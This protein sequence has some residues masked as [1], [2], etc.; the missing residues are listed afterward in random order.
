[1]DNSI[2]DNNFYIISEDYRLINFNESVAKTYEGIKIGDYCYKATMKRNEP[3]KHCP[4]AGNSDCDCPIYYD[5]FYDTWMEAVFAKME[6]GKYAVTCRPAV[7]R[8]IRVFD[9]MGKEEKEELIKKLAGAAANKQLMEIEARLVHAEQEQQIQ[10]EEI[11]TLNEQLIEKQSRTEELA[12]EQEAQIEEIT[13]L[14]IELDEQ[15]IILQNQQERAMLRIKT[16]ADAIRG[17]FRIAKREEGY[18]TKYVSTQLADM[19]G[20]DVDEFMEL[21]KD[22][23]GALIHEEDVERALLNARETVDDNDNHIAAY[24]IRCKDGSWKNVE[25]KSKVIQNYNDEDEIWSFIVDKDE[26]VRISNTLKDVKETKKALEIAREQA[27]SANRAKSAFLFNMSHDIRTPMNA[28]MGFTDLLEKEITDNDTAK[29]Y[30]K[31]I[32]AANSFLLSLINNV[33]EMARI[34]SGKMAVENTYWNVQAFNDTIYSIFTESMNKKNIKF[35]RTVE[36]EHQAILC[37]ATKVREIFLNLLSNALKYTNP[38]GTIIFALKEIPSDREGYALF[39][40]IVEDNGIGMSEQFKEHIFDAFSRERTS[41]E[42]RVEGSGIGMSIVKNLIDIMDG[43][44]DVESEIGKGTKITVTLPHKIATEKDRNIVGQIEDRYA[45]VKFSGKRILLAEDNDLNAEIAQTIL[46]QVDFEVER[47]ENGKRCVEMLQ[48][49][50]AYYY[51]LILMDIQMPEMNGY[52]ATKAIRCLVDKAKAGIPIIAMT[53]NAFEEDKRD[54]LEAGMD[55]HLAK[56]IRINELMKT[57][58]NCLI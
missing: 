58:V 36:V 53:A 47:A 45:D 4:V 39:Q 49:A 55:G 20:Y 29:H 14:N 8:G 3:C 16:M 38:G 51:D 19:L 26:L 10:L 1:M 37:D 13:A 46:S 24:R 40:T 52:E 27:E 31:R 17:G 7:N 43:T 5:P 50:D 34:E 57:M 9:E 42:S 56:P 48:A 18:P 22:T 15:K 28:I 21:T 41:T 54:A 12:A 30:I 6:D 35:I 2:F 23:L 11:R 44:I 32:Q 25:E 33:L